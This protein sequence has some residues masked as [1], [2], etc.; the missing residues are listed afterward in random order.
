MAKLAA[1]LG[2]CYFYLSTLEL[3]NGSHFFY[4]QSGIFKA[5]ILLKVLPLFHIPI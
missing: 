3:T 1:I 2:L 5:T 4:L